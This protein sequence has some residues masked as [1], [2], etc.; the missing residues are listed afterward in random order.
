MTVATTEPVVGVPKLEPRHKDTRRYPHGI[1]FMDGQYLPMSEA[2][3]SVLDWGFLHSDAT[4]D[5][6]HVWAGRFFRLDL[7]LD[8]F[9]RGMERLRMKL[10]YDRQEVERILSNCVALSGHKSAYV[11]MICTRGGSPTFSRDPREAE[12]R[13]IAF[14]V[15]FGSVANKEQLERGLHVGVSETVR[16][17]PKS[18]DPTIK[19]YHWLDLVKGLFDAYDAGAET[20]LVL[21]TNGNIAEGPGF[22]V[23]IVKSG[24]LKTPAFGVLPGITRQTVFDLCKE[25]GLVVTAVDLSRDEL[26]EADEVFITSTAGGIMP[27][28]RVDGSSISS[29]RVGIVTRQLMDLYWQK[30]SDDAWSTPV[31]YA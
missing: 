7:H 31:N 29:G 12:N 11:E 24:Q 1:A 15:P 3:V 20:A 9:F 30:H 5:T 13:F 4:Y 16:I 17:P 19:N 25:V 21:D 6:V 2:K 28:T 8:R 22:N 27:V 10:P 18:V 14:A 26:N 23:F